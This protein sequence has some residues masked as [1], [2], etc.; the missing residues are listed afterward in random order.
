METIE[1]ERKDETI[2]DLRERHEAFV[3]QVREVSERAIQ[4]AGT[5][6]G[7]MHTIGALCDA[8]LTTEGGE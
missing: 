4:R 5:D 3:R 1:L 8:A 2:A 6:L 7:A